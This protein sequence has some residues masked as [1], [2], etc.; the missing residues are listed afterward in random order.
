[1]S[2]GAA[3]VLASGVPEAYA[4]LVTATSG[5]TYQ[6]A[7]VVAAAEP[8]VVVAQVLMQPTPSKV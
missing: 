6:L 5:L 2:A 8:E 3:A 7:A 4:P 1:M